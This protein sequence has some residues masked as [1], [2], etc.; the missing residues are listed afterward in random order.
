MSLTQIFENIFL[1]KDYINVYAIKEGNKAI[2]IDFGSGKILDHLSEID[3]DKVDYILHT[4]Y[5]RDQ[6]YG[7]HRA[8]EQKIKI[9]APKREKKLFNEAEN[10]WKIKSYYNIYY[11][12][13]TFFVSTY[14]IPLDFTFIDNDVF[15]WDSYQFK[16]LG[17]RGHTTGSV[18]YVLKLDNEVIAFTGDLIHSGGKVINY[19]DLEYSYVSDGGKTGIKY[20]LKSLNKLLRH[21]PDILLPSHGDI[22]KEPR[23]DIDSLKKK[24]ERVRSVF[25]LDKTIPVD[26][27]LTLLK[28]DDKIEDQDEFPHIIRKGFG[29]SF[30]VLGNH[31]NC[32]LIDFPGSGD[33]LSYDIDGLN[34]VL[35]DNNVEKIDFVIPTHYHDDHVG[36]IP[37][38]QQKYNVK[39]HA[40]ENI[41]DVLE[42]PTHYRIGCLIDVP[43]KVDTVLRDGEIFERD[44][45]KFQIFH[46][47]GQTEYHSG[48]FTRIDGKSVFFVGDSIGLKIL[49][50]A[51]TNNNCIN[52]CQLGDK[53]GSVKCADILLKWNPEY[54]ASSHLGFIKVDKQILKGYKEHVSQYESVLA[55]LVAQD[56]ANMGFYPNW[57]CFKPIRI[58]SKPGSEFKTNLIVWN[59][60]KR[61]STVEVELNLPKK[62]E[63]E[64]VNKQ[65][66][67]DSN[68][69]MEIPISI[70]IPKSEDP[71]GRTIITANII[72][73]GKDIGP[74]PDLMID[75]GFIP[76]DSWTG[77]TPDKKIELF[78]WIVKSI[79]R[80]IR[81]FR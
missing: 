5:H 25:R 10:F 68:T 13:P 71:K 14:D 35:K 79:N 4:H 40:L 77:W 42:N 44:D 63:A 55:D 48:L 64:F 24:F 38:L 66:I 65:Y 72:W 57:I 78:Q 17:T 69:N 58:I 29:T 15:N 23:N 16:V 30:I 8:L 32:I 46:F 27:M 26:E 36:G 9:A 73:N 59:F 74:F 33:P 12:K 62:W 54:L 61:K 56:N 51:E 22:I 41:V 76:S 3:V 52:F 60:L 45:Y 7:D 50:D 28:T 80:D 1:F 21:A 75:H 53:V 20:S 18:S 70:K 11:F 47:P 81:F 39:V 67:L 2:L 34:R 19:Y 6:C 49:E 43:I 37:L 31:N